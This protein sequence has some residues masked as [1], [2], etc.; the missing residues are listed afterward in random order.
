MRPCLPGPGQAVLKPAVSLRHRTPAEMG[1]LKGVADS[2]F[3]IEGEHGDGWARL[4]SPK[5]RWALQFVR[6]PPPRL[7]PPRRTASHRLSRVGWGLLGPGGYRGFLAKVM[8]NIHL[9]SKWKLQLGRGA[10]QASYSSRS[11]K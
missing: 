6:V 5:S 10:A 1:R 4:L 7:E 9:S 8:K 11:E 3:T 2:G